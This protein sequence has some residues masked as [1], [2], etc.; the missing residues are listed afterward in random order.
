MVPEERSRYYL[1][2]TTIMS[3]HNVIVEN[4]IKVNRYSLMD[5]PCTGI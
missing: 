2:E 1:L 4:V 5:I 3:V